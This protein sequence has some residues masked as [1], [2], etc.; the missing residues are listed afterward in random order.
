M[1]VLE[2]LAIVYIVIGLFVGILGLTL[3]KAGYLDSLHDNISDEIAE[4]IT[5]QVGFVAMLSV[6]WGL[7][8]L[9]VLFEDKWP[10][11]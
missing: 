8:A 3:V 7:A 1:T 5:V 6:L 10:K 9:E 2:V 11:T 4:S